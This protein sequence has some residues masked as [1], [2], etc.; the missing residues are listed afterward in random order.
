MDKPAVVSEAGTVNARRKILTMAISTILLD[1][2]FDTV[3]KQC[4][5]TL[6]EMLQSRK[7]KFTFS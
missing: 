6:S 1:M 4:L 2:G 3:E 5:E 7:F